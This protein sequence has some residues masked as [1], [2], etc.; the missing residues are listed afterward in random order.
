MFTGTVA[1]NISFGKL[2]ATRE[3]IEAAAK[4]ANAHKF[5]YE[6]PNGKTQC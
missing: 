1:E 6:S 3:E 4:L 2:D 5:Y